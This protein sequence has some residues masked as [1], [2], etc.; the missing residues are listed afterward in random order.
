MA[1]L[2]EILKG[3][4]Q[5]I[6][7]GDKNLGV[8][9]K[10]KQQEEEQLLKL[11]EKQ[12]KKR[13]KEAD[14][15]IKL[16]KEEDRQLKQEIGRAKN[17]P[18]MD[19]DLKNR[20]K[21]IRSE[22]LEYAT[23]EQRRLA[24]LPETVNLSEEPKA[25]NGDR[26]KSSEESH[27][28]DAEYEGGQK[29]LKW[30]TGGK[31]S[32]VLKSIP[33]AWMETGEGLSGILGAEGL[34]Q[35]IRSGKEKYEQAI[36]VDDRDAANAQGGRLLGDILNPLGLLGRLG[37]VG[38]LSKYLPKSKYAKSLKNVGTSSLYGAIQAE[39][40]DENPAVGAIV[41]AGTGLALQGLGKALSKA[42]KAKFNKIKERATFTDPKEISER[43]AMM[44][45]K[46]TIPEI[47]GDETGINK[48]KRDSSLFNRKR[49]ESIE[50]NIKKS[51]KSQIKGLPKGE[52]ETQTL[53]GNLGNT[54]ANLQEESGKLYDIVKEE[55]IGK[56]GLIEKRD[57]QKWL[58]AAKDA[59]PDVKG[60]P[61]LKRN[62]GSP[63]DVEKL[64][65]FA[66]EDP[67]AY[68]KFVMEN[69]ETLPTAADFLKYRKSVKK[70]LGSAD[71]TQTE[72]L[73]VL[74][75]E[76][77][78]I[79]EHSDTNSTL[80]KASKNYATKVAPF[81]Q[82]EIKNAIGTSKFSESQ[83]GRPKISTV[84][85]KQSKENNLAFKQLS[86]KDKKRVIGGFL[87]ENSSGEK[88]PIRAMVST[89]EKLPDYIKLN[90]DP[91]IQK[92][93]SEMKQLSNISKTYSSMQRTTTSD[94]GSRQ[95]VEKAAKIARLIGYG[96]TAVTNP[97]MT[98]GIALAEGG[99]RAALA[100]KHAIGRKRLGQKHL[101]H[102][103][104][105]ELLD[106]LYQK[107]MTQLQVPAIKIQEQQQR[108]N[109]E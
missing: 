66:P 46:A 34:K 79:I 23:D 77:D 106:A 96:A 53:Y 36:G 13:Q 97:T 20:R 37:K 47:V 83:E 89:W 26:S 52:Q 31:L 32:D 28:S 108:K 10:G 70:M 80:S 6:A 41:G 35:K 62:A 86:T 98:A 102:Y 5:G 68:Q 4:E 51:A 33:S 72:G 71:S 69:I 90:P 73:T 43:A 17:I 76:L 40:D 100:A 56:G 104:K 82:K 92:I 64:V 7:E 30:M 81:S 9:L 50:G 65:M 3:I 24:G 39:K 88:N 19:S 84:F 74:L 57:L 99:T 78:Q 93:M 75:K 87:E 49:L 15:K 21:E 25:K 109:N 105:P 16:L 61:K 38:K 55:G 91:E 14:R 1:S 54:K 59:A 107:K 63:K 22:I 2:F 67:K 95:S 8:Y 94:I 44:G 101:K 12:E 48:I 18:F 85:G 27:L 11:L 42:K 103:L 45:K 58:K 60:L 29:L